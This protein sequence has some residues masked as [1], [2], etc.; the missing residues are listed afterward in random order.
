MLDVGC[1]D[2]KLRNGGAYIGL[3]K[4]RVEGEQY[5]EFIE[6]WHTAVQ[7]R[8]ACTMASLERR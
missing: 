5:D 3:N 8:C 6:E 2:E 7:V 4:D 1:S